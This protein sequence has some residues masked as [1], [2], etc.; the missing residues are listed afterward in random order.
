ME[1]ISTFKIIPTKSKQELS[2]KKIIT[3]LHD[4]HKTYT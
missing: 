1:K 2:K 3:Y 4:T